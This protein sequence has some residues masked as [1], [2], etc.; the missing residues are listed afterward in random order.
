MMSLLNRL[1]HIQEHEYI[2]AMDEQGTLTKTTITEW[3][4]TSEMLD[5]K[6][7]LLA[8]KCL[9]VQFIDACNSN[10]K[11]VTLDKQRKL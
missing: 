4:P 11:A 1:L 5:R 2:K 10:E 7:G 6:H 9:S 8:W 3:T